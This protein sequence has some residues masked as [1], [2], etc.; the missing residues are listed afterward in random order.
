MV[1][2]GHPDTTG[3]SSIDYYLS[4]DKFHQYP[5]TINSHSLGLER[6]SSEVE[7][8]NATTTTTSI[9]A[10]SST[11][12]AS[13]SSS[14][15]TATTSASIM[16]YKSFT[17]QL[18][19]FDSLG[20]IFD[21]PLL[22][23]NFNKINK[24]LLLQHQQPQL[25]QSE[26]I[27]NIDFLAH[28]YRPIQYYTQIYTT[29]QKKKQ[30]T[31]QQ[32]MNLITL[33]RKNS[34][35]IVLLPQHLP[36]FHPIYDI[37]ILNIILL[38]PHTV[39]T[40][41]DNKKKINWKNTIIKRWKFK[42][43]TIIKNCIYNIYECKKNNIHLYNNIILLKNNSTTTNNNNNKLLNERIVDSYFNRI[44]W[45]DSLNPAE[46][47]MLLAIG[48][49]MLDPFPFG[50]GVTTLESLAVCTPVITLPDAQSVPQ[51]ATGRCSVYV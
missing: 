39:I 11:S 27:E 36:K 22:T 50:G 35:T 8:V 19:L 34:T 45:L 18:V 7:R 25:K 37:I 46:Y 48:D 1:I 26:K 3:Y 49:V 16:A 38:S 4:S 30:K 9:T 40:I 42:L 15:S 51:L 29:L 43:N 41:I 31:S 10:S 47:L 20:F 17:E 14:S 21:R 12:S 24:E 32:L 33:K 44:I 28:I 5:Y 2:W 23:T 13:S 6:A